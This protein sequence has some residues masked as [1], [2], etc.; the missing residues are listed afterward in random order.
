MDAGA[1]SAADQYG[2]RRS[3]KAVRA[4]KHS[5]VRRTF[6]RAALC[7][8]WSEWARRSFVRDYGVDESQTRT[9]APGVDLSRWTSV[10]R[11]QESGLP[12]LLFVGGNLDRKGGNLLLEVFRSH[13]RGRC[14]LDIVTRDELSEED[15][16]RVHRGLEATSPA[17]LELYRNASA[18]V[19]PTRGDCFS[20]ASMEAMAMSL[21]V[22]VSSVG[23]IPEIVEQGRSGFLIAPGD[24]KS[25]R[26]DRGLLADPARRR[27]WGARGR[28]L[29]EER[30]D[31][32]KV[33]HRLLEL[34]T[35]IA[36]NGSRR[37]WRWALE[38]Q[39]QRLPG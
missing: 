24:G 25:A 18:F 37:A 17:L 6:R 16:V 39:E 19:L 1:A 21:P 31:A 27:E 34:L 33:A 9:V 8:G 10:D 4:L 12:R 23:G 26:S 5:L 2:I 14:L 20:I 15:G 22:V 30:Y 35:E 13:F 38:S 36:R 28:V 32:K 29:A 3:S 7:V 11:G